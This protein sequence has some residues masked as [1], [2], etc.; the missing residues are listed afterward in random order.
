MT[1]A[2]GRSEA[3]AVSSDGNKDTTAPVAE[4]TTADAEK[5]EKLVEVGRWENC[6]RT[7]QDFVGA[8]RV[9]RKPWYDIQKSEY[10]TDVVDC[11]CLI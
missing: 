4:E 8:T 11:R 1:V 7:C 3:K 9:G 5:P 6:K 2:D 10:N